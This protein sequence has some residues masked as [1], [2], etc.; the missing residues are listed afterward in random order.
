MPLI[1]TP[2]SRTPLK[3]TPLLQN[4]QSQ[5]VQLQNLQR[6]NGITWD[7][8][9]SVLMSTPNAKSG[10]NKENAKTTPSGVFCFDE[11]AKCKE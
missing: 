3:L 5:L 6:S 7:L 9:C 1:P 10:K 8:V 2:L 4:H 11:Y